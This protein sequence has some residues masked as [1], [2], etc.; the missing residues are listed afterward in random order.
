[1]SDLERA[2]AWAREATT[3]PPDANET[4]LRENWRIMARALLAEHERANKVEARL[5]AVSSQETLDDL[6]ADARRWRA[7]RDHMKLWVEEDVWCIPG[8]SWRNHDETADTAADAL[9]EEA[10]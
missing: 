2:L 6:F 9:A 3:D 8:N 5:A 4:P 1:M 7:V 10:Q